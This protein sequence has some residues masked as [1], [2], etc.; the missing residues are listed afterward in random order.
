MWFVVDTSGSISDGMIM[1][2]Y[3][4]IASAIEIFGGNIESFLSFTE[5][6]ITKPVP[7]SSIDDLLS[8]IPKGGGGNN[9]KLIFKYLE[10]GEGLVLKDKQGH[11]ISVDKIIEPSCIVIITDGYDEFPKESMAKGIPVLWLINNNDVIPPWGMV[12]RI[13]QKNNQR[14]V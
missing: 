6:F 11:V 9:F 1:D 2:A 13:P 10:T 7:F 14:N 8:I 12:A 4:E 5:S 3:N